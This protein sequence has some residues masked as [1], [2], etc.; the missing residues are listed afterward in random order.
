MAD[1]V[2]DAR[3]GEILPAPATLFRTDQPNEIVARAS[4]TATALGGVIEQR[5]LYAVIG[6][7]KHVR[8]EGW[9]LLGSMLGVFPIC[10]WSRRMQDETGVPY[11]WEAR[12]EARTR[13]G[14][15]I[16]AAEAQCTRHEEQ[17]SFDPTGRDGRKLPPRDDYA[18]RSMAQTRATSKALRLPLGFIM[19]M[20]GYEATPA[21]EMPRDPRPERGRKV[22]PAERTVTLDR[23]EQLRRVDL[24]IEPEWFTT[25]VG[26]GKK[27]HEET[28]G[29][30]TE[31][32]L[33]G[34]RVSWLRFIASSKDERISAYNRSR[35]KAALDWAEALEQQRLDRANAAP[36]DGAWDADAPPPDPFG[37]E[38]QP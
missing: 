29:T 16:G 34:E 14:A 38:A 25:K 8:V 24:T 30:M 13:D 1:E 6:T 10:V 2:I 33:E 11:G 23:Q 35:A 19:E 27:F 7:K 28:W 37:E 32:G 31:G 20:A 36:D 4:A 12:V 9:T 5:K 17:W 3:T 22:H 26:F 18:L 21:E 15:L